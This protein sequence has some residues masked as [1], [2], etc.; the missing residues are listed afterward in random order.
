MGEGSSIA[1]SCGVGHRLTSIVM[2]VAQSSA[3]ALIQP[4]AQEL[5]NAAGVTLK[6]KKK[7]KIP[8]FSVCVYTY[9]CIFWL[10][11]WHV[12]VPRPG[13]EPSPQQ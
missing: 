11:L 6:R 10:C 7:K 1:A 12:E 2:T 4:T 3:A 8:V 5:P 9:M 13:N